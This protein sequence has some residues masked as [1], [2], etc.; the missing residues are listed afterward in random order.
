[1]DAPR[2]VLF[3]GDMTD[4]GHLD[5]FAEF[6]QVY[7]RTGKEGLLRFPVFEAIGNHDVNTTSPI[8][9][10][11]VARHGA[12]QYSFDW[13]DLHFVCLDMFPDAHT[14]SF[15]A[16]D[17]ARVGR[18]RPVILYFHYSLEGPYSDF[19]E[20]EEKT[21]F[22]RAI[23]GYNVLAIFHGHEHR[24]GHYTWKGHPVFRP[25]A[26]RHSSHHFLSVRVGQARMQVAARDFDTRRWVQSWSVPVRR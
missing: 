7:G 5:E 1:V 24:M 16:R 12:I 18:Q 20:P 17:L 19:W 4:N 21:A 13:D 9:P 14:L 23:A 25:G 22:G 3:T 8:K 15:L 11:V 2:G 6:E 10:R 26:P